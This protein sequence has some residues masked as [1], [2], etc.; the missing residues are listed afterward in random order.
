MPG[1]ADSF[2]S[3]DYAGGELANPGIHMKLLTAVQVSV[4][5]SESYSRAWQ[6]MNRFLQ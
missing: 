3:G 6:K 5:S 1:F 2:W 4:F